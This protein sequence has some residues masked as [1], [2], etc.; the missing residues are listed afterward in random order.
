ML[1]DIEGGRIAGLVMS[2]ESVGPICNVDY[3]ATLGVKI[4]KLSLYCQVEQVREEI[5]QGELIAGVERN[6]TLEIATT[7]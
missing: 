6:A 5:R 3:H 2:L 1:T 7:T 4:A